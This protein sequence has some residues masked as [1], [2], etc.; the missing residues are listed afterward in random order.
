MLA[1]PMQGSLGARRAAYEARWHAFGR[2]VAG[3]KAGITYAEVPWP[4]ERP[5]DMQAVLLYGVAGAAEARPCTVGCIRTD[6]HLLRLA[7]DEDNV[8]LGSHFKIH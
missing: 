1:C 6:L 7:G 3:G 8:A 5:E 2:D 4:A